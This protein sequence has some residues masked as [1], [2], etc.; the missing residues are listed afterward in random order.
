MAAR[1][2]RLRNV[3]VTPLSR[4]C[5]WRDKDPMGAATGAGQLQAQR[6]RNV[7]P[8]AA[9]AACLRSSWAA[10]LEEATGVETEQIKQQ[11]RARISAS[12]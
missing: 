5:C 9:L 10:G 7:S 12:P 1:H 3:C 6:G 8:G 4:Q 2:L 11:K